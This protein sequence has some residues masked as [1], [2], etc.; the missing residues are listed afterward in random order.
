MMD[1][2]VLVDGARIFVSNT[3]E[4]R[5][6]VLKAF[7]DNGFEDVFAEN[8]DM[9]H[10]VAVGSVDGDKPCILGAIANV[11]DDL[12]GQYEGVEI[13]AGENVRLARAY[14]ES[15]GYVESQRIKD[16]DQ[17]TDGVE[18]ATVY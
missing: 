5:D 9:Y 6:K 4:M 11:L 10:E 12:K 2:T 17:W 14:M 3:A 1:G 8:D 7:H 13:L 15:R 16:T 18:Y